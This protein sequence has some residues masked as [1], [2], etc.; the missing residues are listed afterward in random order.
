MKWPVCGLILCGFVGFGQTTSPPIPQVQDLAPLLG[1]RELAL[2]KETLAQDLRILWDTT[3]SPPAAQAGN[4]PRLIGSFR[5]LDRKRSRPLGKRPRSIELS[6]DQ[7]LVVAVNSA[8]DK[9]ISWSLIPDPRII[10]A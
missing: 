2:S 1:I 6:P 3:A 8:G 7:L 5:V 9:L 10:R 4:Q